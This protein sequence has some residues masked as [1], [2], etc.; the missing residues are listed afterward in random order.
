MTT[1]VSAGFGRL[2]LRPQFEKTPSNTEQLAPELGAHSV[3]ILQ[4]LG[5]GPAEIAD[6]TAAAQTQ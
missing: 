2:G 5:Y 4:E 6:L 3:E 1:R